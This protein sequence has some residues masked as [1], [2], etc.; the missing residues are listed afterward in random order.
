ML[1]SGDVLVGR[2]RVEQV[3]GAAE[4][5]R[6]WRAR[7]LLGERLGDPDPYVAIKV[8]SDEHA[9]APDATSLLHREFVLTRRL[10]HRHVVRVERFDIDPV[11]RRA[12]FTMELMRGLTLKQLQRERPEGLPWPELREIAVQLLDALAHAHDCGILHGDLKPG[13]VMLTDQGLRLFDF[14]QGRGADGVLDDLPRVC[15]PRN[16]VW[17]TVY[18][19]P[20]LLEGGMLTAAA[21]IYAAA[22][23]IYELACGTHP[24]LRLDALRARA[25]RLDRALRMPRSLP[26][27]CRSVLR[28][29][30]A[31]DGH[32]R[33]VDARELYRAFAQAP[34]GRGRC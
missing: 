19:A 27:G 32:E 33:R 3:L 1:K 34:A 23:V 7:D 26:P 9:Q 17:S 29:A 16:A 2:Y 13:S 4:V 28:R 24:F 21:D 8:L 22:C 6:V 10:H 11:Q 25:E 31:L 12:F 5:C 15:R 18:A 14:S 30:L 20:E